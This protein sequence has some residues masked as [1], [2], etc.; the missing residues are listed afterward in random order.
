[1]SET[2]TIR[3]KCPNCGAILTVADNPANVGKS[4]MCPVC[5]EKHEFSEFKPVSPKND[6]SDRTSL[7]FSPSSDV[8]TELPQMP[9]VVSFGYLLHDGHQKKYTLTSGINL[10]G[11]KTYQTASVAT[12][13][14]ETNDLGFSRRHLYI[15]AVKGPD[16][17]IRHYAYNAANKNETTINGV[18]LGA[19]DKVVL[20]DS[21]VIHSAE[22]TLVFKVTELNYRTSSNDSDKTEI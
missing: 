10:V 20:H 17:V 13:P 9:K 8:K 7:G 19:E 15:E 3:I 4:V 22:T 12:I 21:D 5:K 1:M 18:L 11:R 14:I 16:G 6:D 2:A